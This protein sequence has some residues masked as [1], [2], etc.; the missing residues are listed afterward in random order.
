MGGRQAHGRAPTAKSLGNRARKQREKRE[1]SSSKTKDSGHRA[2]ALNAYEIAAKLQPANQK[3]R[4]RD[5]IAGVSDKDGDGADSRG[6]PPRKK[7]R[8][9]RAGDQDESD[10]EYGSDD[11]GNK[12]RLG[13]PIDKDEDSEIES[14]DAFG[15]SDEEKF[16]DFTFGGSKSKDKVCDG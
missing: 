10:V 9:N 6:G 11:E 16:K 12:W 13:G 3:K 2:K 14:D 8:A 7:P 4:A 15:E 1:Q 5:R